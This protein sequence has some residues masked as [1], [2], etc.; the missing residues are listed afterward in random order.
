MENQNYSDILMY[1]KNGKL[2]KGR[3]DTWNFKTVADRY[4]INK[5]NQLTRGD[6]IVLKENDLNSVWQTFHGNL[7]IYFPPIYNNFSG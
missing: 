1:K 5:R 2:P 6:K 7:N 4:G 3:K